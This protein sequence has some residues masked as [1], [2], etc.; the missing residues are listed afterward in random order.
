MMV[1]RKRKFISA[2]KHFDNL[3]QLHSHHYDNNLITLLSKEEL[4]NYYARTS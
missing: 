2:N 4:V 3:L 1:K